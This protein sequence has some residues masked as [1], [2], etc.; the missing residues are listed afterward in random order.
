MTRGA[1]VVMHKEVL[2]NLRDRRSL[3]AAVLYPLLGPVLLVTLLVVVGRTFSE[4]AETP[5][6]LPVAGA[7]RA[8]DLIRFLEQNGAEIEPAPA[9]PEAAVAKGDVD[10]VLVIPDGYGAAFADG[11]PATVQIVVDASRQS[12]AVAIRRARRLV[13]AYR[14]QIAALRLVARGVSPVVLAPLAVETVDVATPQS[15]AA[16]F[17]NLTPYFLIY[18]IFIGGMYLAIDTTAGERERGSLEPLLLNP[19]PRASL[20]LGKLGATLAFTL[21]AVVE[22]ILAFAVVL[23]VLPLEQYLGM[24]L[25]LSAGA[26]A[27]VFVI[28]LP[29]LPLAAALQLII[30][31]FT[32]S[33][34]EAQNYL[35][36]LPLLPALPGMFLAFVPVAP[37]PAAM[38]IPTF[39]QQILINQVMRGEA[40]DPLHLAISAGVTLLLGLALVGLAIRLYG[41]ERVVFGR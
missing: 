24:R 30:A 8:P 26:L 17:L 16:G 28:A 41:R 11:R 6:A 23:N 38:S 40:I 25:S 34:K 2:D 3:A 29:M 22:T 1:W 10:V 37:T 39:G 20:V 19:V 9:D 14:E 33:F 4:Q 5:L 31:S 12:D 7:E 36:L 35:S 32:G 21:V 18:A 13:D 27:M 15:Q